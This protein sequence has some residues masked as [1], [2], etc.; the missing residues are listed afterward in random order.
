MGA[1]LII[2]A[3]HSQIAGVEEEVQLCTSID[4]DDV[5][6]HIGRSEILDYLGLKLRVSECASWK[7]FVVFSNDEDEEFDSLDASKK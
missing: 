2:A 5:N 4:L 1:L 3:V 6:G 7:N